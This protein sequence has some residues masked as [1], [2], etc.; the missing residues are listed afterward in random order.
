MAFIIEVPCDKI[1]TAI[2]QRDLQKNLC[3]LLT[4][5]GMNQLLIPHGINRTD[6][7]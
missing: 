3:I 1:R 7:V 5:S 4:K 2:I 6:E